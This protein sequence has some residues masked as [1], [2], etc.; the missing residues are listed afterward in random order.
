MQLSINLA[1][2]RVV[3]IQS[4]TRGPVK[5]ENQKNGFAS[6]L[7]AANSSKGVLTGRR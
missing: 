7:T 2:L 1:D 5:K 3:S 6:N 4:R